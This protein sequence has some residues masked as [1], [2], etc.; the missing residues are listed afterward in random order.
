MDNYNEAKK[1]GHIIDDTLSVASLTCKAVSQLALDRIKRLSDISLLLF[2][3]LRAAQAGAFRSAQAYLEFADG[4]VD[5]SVA[6]TFQ[7]IRPAVFTFLRVSADVAVAT[8]NV[9]PAI[10]RVS[11]LSRARCWSDTVN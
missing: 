3:A 9:P 5:F 2:Q 8:K 4:L 10:T 6:E 7:T 11:A 1:H